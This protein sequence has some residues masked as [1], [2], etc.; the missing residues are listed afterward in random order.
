MT[1]FVMTN[2][3]N[4]NFGTILREKR[5]SDG[6]KTKDISSAS[7]IDQA[8]ISKIE[9]GSRMPT[10]KQLPLLASA[11]AIPFDELHKEYLVQKVLE[12]VQYVD[13]PENILS[14]AETRIEYLR[15]EQ[16]PSSIELSEDI[17]EQLNQLDL[18]KQKWVNQRPLE[19]IQLTKL[20][21]YFNIKNTFESNR[22]EGNTLT[23]QETQL[24][25]NEGLTIGGKPLKDH[26]EAINHAEAVTYLY[27][28]VQVIP[29]LTN[30]CCWIFTD[31]S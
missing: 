5:V 17:L 22:I 7:K 29:N 9:N 30:E 15:N 6:K 11:Y 20:R 8:I 28:L 13:F 31:L 19:G 27:E 14:V 4:M 2:L 25:V 21:E 23:Y 18:L 26:L 16:K 3:V 1:N 12:V 10:E 24:V